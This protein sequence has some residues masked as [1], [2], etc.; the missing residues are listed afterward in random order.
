MAFHHA[1]MAALGLGL[2]AG[3]AAAGIVLFNTVPATVRSIIDVAGLHAWTRRVT[4]PMRLQWGRQWHAA[5]HHATFRLVSPAQGHDLLWLVATRG[6]I[7]AE[8]VA[9]E[10]SLQIG[11]TT[12]ATEV[13]A[14]HPDYETYEPMVQLRVPEG[15][16]DAM[17]GLASRF[18]VG[19]A[20]CRVF[21]LSHLRDPMGE[22][23]L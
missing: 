14:L 19:R 13:E 7:P 10:V 17:Q 12:Y 1:R 22:A 2:T 4:P 11:Q 6:Q 21:P 20:C 3:V 8:R 16:S 23:I 9:E 15:C 5:G 18:S